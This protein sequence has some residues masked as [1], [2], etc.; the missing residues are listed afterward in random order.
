MGSTAFRLLHTIIKKIKLYT[1]HINVLAD[2]KELL[3]YIEIWDKIVDLFNKKHNKSVLYNNII[4]NE[5]IKAKISSY[6]E[7]FHGNKKLIKDK[8]YGNSIL[9]IE[10]I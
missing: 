1:N 9:L 2:N 6:N 4:Y 8:Y 5:C 7:K 10:S 3:K